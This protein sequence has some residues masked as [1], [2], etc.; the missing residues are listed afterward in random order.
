MNPT[1]QIW[2]TDASL[3]IRFEHRKQYGLAVGLGDDYKATFW[4][5]ERCNTAFTG[6]ED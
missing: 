1:G 4:A 2:E 5:M 6:D 3:L